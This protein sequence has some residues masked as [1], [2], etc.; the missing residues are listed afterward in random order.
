MSSVN[1]AEFRSRSRTKIVATIGPACSAENSLQELVLAGVDV[2]RINMAHGSVE[3]HAE[4]VHFIRQVSARLA[5]PIGILVDLAGPKIRLGELPGDL[6]DCALGGLLR[7]VRGESSH[8]PNELV[9]TYE[10]LI[11]ELTLG[12]RVM[13]AD[14]TVTLQ[15]IQRE[16]DSALCRVTQA[17]VVRSRQGVNLPG[18][19]LST[20]AM[21][22]I[23]QEH[24]EWAARMEADFIGLSFVR[25]PADVT[26]LKALL[27][28]LGSRA[29][30]VAKI[31]KPEA[32]AQLE[33]II[34]AT[35]AV[36]VARGDLGVESD[37]A[38]VPVVQKRIIELC[39]LHQK[40]VITATQML[41]SM[42]NSPR[43]TRAEASDVANAILDGTDACM[44]SG[45]T[46]IG[47]FPRQ[48]VEMMNRIALATEE[49]LAEST[50]AFRAT[51]SIEGLHPVTQAVV[52]G[53]S[54]M[55][56]E[57]G[58]RLIVGVSHSGVT[59]LAL[60]KQRS[61]VPSIGVSDS[62]QSLRQ[63]S[64][65]WGVTPVFDLHGDSPSDMVRRVD[66]WGR[67]EQILQH[68]D[69]IIIV[70]GTY[71]QVSGHNQVL[72]HEINHPLLSS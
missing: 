49:L 58:A 39:R 44:L 3:E 10:P 67:R 60:S 47:K 65:Y 20:P 5:R 8:N 27:K 36:M 69:R 64:L 16:P 66:E 56:R 22:P 12:D 32:L 28:Q 41:D 55:A 24:A 17:G 68:G 2:F 30:V 71:G 23:D 45:E 61:V 54:L 48:A 38:R 62:A 37:V 21:T 35:D 72:V 26:Q 25:S 29:K 50:P 4:Q 14:G 19:K 42:Q 52:H 31:E 34:R 1:V 59:S 70:S 46:A 9:T 13:L 57:L 11:D 40:P 18:V 15:V 43:P 6:L 33:A 51:E 7:F 63:M 53:A